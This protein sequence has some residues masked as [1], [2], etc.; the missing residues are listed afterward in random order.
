[1]LRTEGDHLEV[2]AVSARRE[3]VQE[4]NRPGESVPLASCDFACSSCLPSVVAFGSSAS[5]PAQ[6][7]KVARPT[8]PAAAL[9]FLARLRTRWYSS[10][11]RPLLQPSPPRPSHAVAPTLAPLPPAVH[12]PF[13][14]LSAASLSDAPSPL[15]AY[16]RGAR[17]A[18][19]AAAPSPKAK[20]GTL[21]GW[22]G[23]SLRRGRS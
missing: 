5:R 10:S 18:A 2:F 20:G 8:P 3:G 21:R 12:L 4:R 19:P 9:L 16:L 7:Y 6:S 1:M 11:P 15:R 13:V 14:H 17:A 22:L 23:A